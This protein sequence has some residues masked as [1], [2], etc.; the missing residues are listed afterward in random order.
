[1][2]QKDF[3]FLSILLLLPSLSSLVGAS[4]YAFDTDFASGYVAS[5]APALSEFRLGKE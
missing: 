3:L 5:G 1:M 4:P 2:N